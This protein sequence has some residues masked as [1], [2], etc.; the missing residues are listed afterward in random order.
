[1]VSSILIMYKQIK[2]RSLNARIFLLYLRDNKN[3]QSQY[4]FIIGFFCKLQA[5][6]VDSIFN[7]I[8]LG[9]KLFVLYHKAELPG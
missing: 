9:L 3:A 4:S 2:R 1:M 7:F 8:F 6:L 5:N